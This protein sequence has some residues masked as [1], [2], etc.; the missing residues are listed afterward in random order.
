VSPVYARH[1]DAVEAKFQEQMRKG[2][3]VERELI[4]K[5]HLGE[6]ALKAAGAGNGSAK[7]Q[8]R[9]R[10][11]AQKVPGGSGKGDTATD[12]GKAGNTPE[13]RLKGVYI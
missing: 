13:A 8:A 3:P 9:D 6:L 11:A 4:L 10:V 5:L 1:A 12:R 2:A 7:R